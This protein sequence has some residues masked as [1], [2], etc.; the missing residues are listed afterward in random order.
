[1]NFTRAEVRYNCFAMK[2]GA[3]PKR[4]DI[5]E[6][7][8]KLKGAL[9]WSTYLSEWDVVVFPERIAII[10][11]I[12][13][14]SKVAEV[15]SFKYVAE[16]TGVQMDKLTDEEKAIIDMVETQFLEGRMNWLNYRKV[17]G[18]K[19]DDERGR[20]ETYLLNVPS[21]QL[22]VTQEMIKKVLERV[23][24]DSNKLFEEISKLRISETKTE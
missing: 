23:T 4:P 18:V 13:D 9:E 6:E 21:N 20:V 5:I 3:T 17:W 12:R 7:I 14:L 1:M 8:E 11:T 2:R 22:E 19:W 24:A 16:K 15:C 10:Q